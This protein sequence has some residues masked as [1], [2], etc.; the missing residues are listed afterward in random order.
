ME[1]R[2]GG[3]WPLTSEPMP[4]PHGWRAPAPAVARNA[5]GTLA[6][7]AEVNRHHAQRLEAHRR[8]S[9]PAPEEV[10]DDEPGEHS[11]S[12]ARI[13]RMHGGDD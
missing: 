1:A 5:A 12:R 7:A 6:A 8:A 9:S 10:G 4:A 3:A 11:L 13:A 2:E